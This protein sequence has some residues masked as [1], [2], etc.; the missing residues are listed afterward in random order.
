M[1]EELQFI[2]IIN[3]YE[4]HLA[5]FQIYSTSDSQS[6]VWTSIKRIFFFYRTF[7]PRLYFT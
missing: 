5:A 1:E 2:N 3:I 7:Q 6:L 4:L